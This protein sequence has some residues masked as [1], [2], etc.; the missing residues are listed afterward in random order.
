MNIINVLTSMEYEDNDGDRKM[1]IYSYTNYI[2]ATKGRM[3][4]TLI[5]ISI[6]DNL[7]RKERI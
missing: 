3:R 6:P 5:H 2:P 1:S 7:K 4:E